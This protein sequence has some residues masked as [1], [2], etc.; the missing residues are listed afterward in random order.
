MSASS[1]AK[2]DARS[3][4]FAGERVT[5]RSFGGAAAKSALRC[6]LHGDDG[7]PQVGA[8]QVSSA[9]LS[10]SIVGRGEGRGRVTTLWSVNTMKS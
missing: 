6:R 9:P 4:G 7:G 5:A 10:T 1:A 8:F 2:T 3:P